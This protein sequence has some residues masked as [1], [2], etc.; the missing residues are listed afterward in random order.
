M[1]G[2]EGLHS[3]LLMEGKRFQSQKSFTIHLLYRRDF[4]GVPFNVSHFTP[5]NQCP[6]DTGGVTDY[7][8]PDNVR[9][10]TLMGEFTGLFK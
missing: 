10:C 2:Q 4:P 5:R 7:D 3:T 9:N 1:W 6:S 8:D